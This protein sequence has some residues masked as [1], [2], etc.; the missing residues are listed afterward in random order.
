MTQSHLRQMIGSLIVAVLIVVVTIA[1]V[2]AKLG[3]DGDRRRD[4]REEE[5]NDNSGTGSHRKTG[6]MLSTSAIAGRS[7]DHHLVL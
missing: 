2:T 6:L 4:Q 1:L 7:A 3:P 5:D